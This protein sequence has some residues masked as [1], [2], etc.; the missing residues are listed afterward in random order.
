MWLDKW[1]YCDAAHH[2]NAITF[3]RLGLLTSGP[4]ELYHNTPTTTER[5]ALDS[6]KTVLFIESMIGKWKCLNEHHQACLCRS[7]EPI[8]SFASTISEFYGAQTLVEL[9]CPPQ[10]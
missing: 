1:G 9:A 2:I 7:C 5:H 4:V 10:A 8:K 6:S 3:V